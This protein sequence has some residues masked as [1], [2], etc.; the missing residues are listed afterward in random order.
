[1]AVLYAKVVARRS[2]ELFAK[3]RRHMGHP[4]IHALAQQWLTEALEE[5]EERL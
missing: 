3:V 2:A 1:M 4:D 5:L